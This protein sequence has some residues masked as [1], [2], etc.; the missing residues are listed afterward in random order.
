[1]GALPQQ[2][3]D[4]MT[5]ITNTLDHAIGQLCSVKYFESRANV[6]E[7]L[8]RGCRPWLV[9]YTVSLVTR[10]SGCGSAC[11]PVSLPA[12][13]AYLVDHLSAFPF[14]HLLLGLCSCTGQGRVQAVLG[15]TVPYSHHSLNSPTHPYT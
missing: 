8:S 7:P 3:T 12:C 9:G 4:A 13:L 10:G 2:A 1:M 14:L 5:Y 11:R 6:P 15:S